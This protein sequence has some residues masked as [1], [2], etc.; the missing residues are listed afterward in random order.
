MAGEPTTFAD[1]VKYHAPGCVVLAQVEAFERLYTWTATAGRTVTWQADIT[2]HTTIHS[3]RTVEKV[4]VTDPDIDP[5]AP[6]QLTSRASVALVDANPGSF[7]FDPATS[8]AYVSLA[9]NS[10]PNGKITSVAFTLYFTSGPPD[11]GSIFVDSDDNT[12]VP[13]VVG[14]PN[15]SRNVQD[16]FAGVVTTGG[17]DL[18]LI[19]ASGDYDDL[20]SS[21]IWED[22]HV[23][24]RLGGD[25]LPF[26]QYNRLFTGTTQNKTWN[27]REF[28]LSLKDGNEQLK[29]DVTSVVHAEAD[30]DVSTTYTLG[31]PVGAT[32]RLTKN[33]SQIGESKIPIGEPKP[34]GY[35]VLEGIRPVPIAVGEATGTFNAE[36]VFCLTGHSIMSVESVTV[37]SHTV[38]RGQEDDDAKFHWHY[39]LASGLIYIASLADVTDPVS[40]A[41]D[42]VSVNFTGKPIT[43][44]GGVMDNFADIVEDLLDHAGITTALDSAVL[45][46]SRFLCNLFAARIYIS[47]KRQVRE[48]LDKICVSTLAYFYLSNAGEYRFDVWAPS[49]QSEVTLTEASGDFVS[50]SAVT[51][52]DR[53]F[54]RV[55]VEYGSNPS[56][57][58]G[59]FLTEEVR[60]PEAVGVVDRDLPFVVEETF[61]A[62]KESAF[63]L[64]TRYARF[65]EKPAAVFEIETKLKPVA[66]DL[67]SRG[68]IEKARLP[69]KRPGADMHFCII[70]MTR[71]LQTFLT[72]LTVDDQ[73]VIGSQA[74]IAA[75]NSLAWTAATEDERDTT[76]FLTDANG[77]ID[78]SI[79][80]SRG[81]SRYY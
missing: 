41:R 80:A 8:I 63:V 26:S 6:V 27:E 15:S 49:V 72:R 24:I 79:P 61:L 40:V 20:F 60:R 66:L 28:V 38:T 64:G 37:G 14:V 3:F 47:S 29:T 54:T 2:Q 59:E 30:A 50:I 18:R 1:F 39:N 46:R 81:R 57:D 12:Y 44:T 53:L 76:G 62:D 52:A 13:L 75:D 25:R 43:A 33:P 5:P 74:F 9:D 36:G 55:Q 21:Y 48:I 34:I 56:R 77:Y 17:G 78:P 7:H 11:A 10:T 16:P 45:A 68:I 19:S 70:G 4:R 73:R 35:G 31:A 23:E 42:L 65:F 71:N 67:V 51:Q 32:A 69:I 22:G 58:G